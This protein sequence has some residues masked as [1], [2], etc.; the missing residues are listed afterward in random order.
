[1]LTPVLLVAGLITLSVM[2]RRMAALS[3]LAATYALALAPILPAARNRC[4]RR[5]LL[6]YAVVLPVFVGPFWAGL[7]RGVVVH[8][9]V[10][11]GR[12]SRRQEREEQ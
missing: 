2:G 4:P 3:I 8:R 5:S 9:R 12:Q 6:A 10:F 1:M 11:R 7:V